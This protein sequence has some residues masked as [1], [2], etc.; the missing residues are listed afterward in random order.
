MVTERASQPMCESEARIK[1]DARDVEVYF[2]F[3]LPYALPVP[4]GDPHVP[5][6]FT[7]WFGLDDLRRMNADHESEWHAD[8]MQ[9]VVALQFAA[10]V[11]PQPGQHDDLLG[12]FEAIPDLWPWVETPGHDEPQGVP[13]D[14]GV[15]MVSLVSVRVRHRDGASR[16]DADH[17]GY[18]TECLDQAL[19]GVQDLQRAISLVAPFPAPILVPAD[20]PLLVPYS[21]RLADQGGPDPV[22]LAVFLNPKSLAMRRLHAPL[23]LSKSDLDAA[24]HSVEQEAPFVP[25]I[26]VFRDAEWSLITGDYWS[27]VIKAAAFTELLIHTTVRHLLWEEGVSPE[28]AT[29]RL[30]N[31]RQQSMVVLANNHLSSKLK[32]RW[33]AQQEGPV[34]TWAQDLLTVRNAIL[35]A[36]AAVDEGMAAKAVAAAN[37]MLD[38]IKEC[39]IEPS[40]RA[41]YPI[42]AVSLWGEPGLRRRNAF[43]R[44]VER[45]L[46]EVEPGYGHRFALWKRAVEAGEIKV[47]PDEEDHLLVAVLAQDRE[48]R[49]VVWLLGTPWAATARLVEEP[50][51]AYQKGLAGVRQHLSRT[52]HP[53]VEVSLPGFR[54]WERTSDWSLAYHLLPNQNCALR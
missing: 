52:G 51:L 36:G 4:L 50:P 5:I 39:L 19:R 6:D 42:T 37:G 48:V 54:G 40:V 3:R 41:K 25:V 9:P 43:T 17:E 2:L 8:P 30:A 33:G 22:P 10:S 28:D 20:L 16:W 27:A 53:Q 49:W 34:R 11:V 7:Q 26:H 1:P 12:V 24:L 38:F 35:H 47:K 45:K 18:V 15:G 46:G 21:V 29:A 14:L 44:R 31:Q 13:E 23:E 32:G